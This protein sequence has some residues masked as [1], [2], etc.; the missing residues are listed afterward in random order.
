MDYDK[1]S[2]AELI[3]RLATFEKVAP[4]TEARRLLH[5]LQV[6]QAELEAQNVELRETQ[7]RLEESRDLYAELYDFAPVGYVTFNDRGHI[8]QINLTGAA[9]LGAERKHLADNP[10][11]VYL[12]REHIQSF[13]RYL[14]Q[15][16]DSG[17]RLSHVTKIRRR[18]GTVLDVRLESVIAGEPSVCRSIMIDITQQ[19]RLEGRLREQSE[20]LVQADRRKDEF[21]A[22]LAHELRN[23]LAPIHNAVEV[24]RRQTVP[25]PQL[26]DWALRLI[27]RQLGHITRLVDDLL[28]V[29]RLTHGK[30]KFDKKPVELGQIVN[31]GIESLAPAVYAARPRLTLTPSNKPLWVRGDP[32][33]LV[34]VVENLL[35]NAAHCTDDGGNI[36]VSITRDDA[37]AVIRVADTGMGITPEKLLRIFDPFF[38]DDPAR[39]GLGLG[40]TVVKKLVVEHDGT[41]HAESAGVGKGS[42]FI[43]RLPLIDDPADVVAPAVEK[44][45]RPAGPPRR[46]LVVDDNH[47][48]AESLSALLDGMGHKVQTVFDGETALAA[49]SGFHPDVIIVDLSLPGIDGYEVATRLRRDHPANDFTMVAFTGF[50]GTDVS[51]RVYAAGFDAH[52]LKPGTIEALEK[53]LTAPN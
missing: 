45:S 35:M 36:S 26:L 50:G 8:G 9:M 49:V 40:L 18:D 25:D 51:R 30:I 44:T 27:S 21:L 4:S 42:S 20:Q 16:F 12:V 15:V 22:M 48:V 47:D 2:K 41:V 31:Q 28:D 34:Q 37:D 33:R 1:L 13:S 24:V 17:E 29:E 32:T 52:L 19:N 14:R 6:H 10:F 43:V 3:K 53:I 46:I 38:Q 11:T 5:E 23:P 39:G 7:Q